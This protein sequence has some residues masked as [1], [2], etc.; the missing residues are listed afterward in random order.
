MVPTSGTVLLDGRRVD[1]WKPEDLRRGIGYGIQSVGLFPHYTVG[2]NVGAVP[3][4]LHWPR[5]GLPIEW[6][7]FCFWSGWNRLGTATGIPTNCQ[8]ARPNASASPEHSRPIR[9]CFSL[10]SLLALWIR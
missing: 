8:A 6:R 2:K 3:S 1:S 7:S 4:L 10:M 5:T 9:R